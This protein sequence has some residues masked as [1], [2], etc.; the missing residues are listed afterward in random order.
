MN[1]KDYVLILNNIDCYIKF[2]GPRCFSPSVISNFQVTYNIKDSET[3]DLITKVS[4]SYTA[5]K[6]FPPK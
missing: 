3:K 5:I 1:V 4:K 2:E 6:I